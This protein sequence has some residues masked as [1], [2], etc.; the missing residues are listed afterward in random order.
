MQYGYN[1]ID[2]QYKYNTNALHIQM[3][4]QYGYKYNVFTTQMQY[5]YNTSII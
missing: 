5:K 2:M 3:H 1:A 4:V